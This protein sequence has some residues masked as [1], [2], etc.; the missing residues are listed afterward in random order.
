M[1][2]EAEDHVIVFVIDKKMIRKV[3][4]KEKV[5]VFCTVAGRPHVIEY[6]DLPESLA[7]QTNPDGSLR[8]NAGSIAIHI[9]E[10][11]FAAAKRDH[12]HVVQH[13][14]AQ[15]VELG[16]EHRALRVVHVRQHQRDR[17]AP[18]G[19]AAQV[20]LR[21][22]QRL[23]GHVHA[24]QH[25]AHLGAMQRVRVQAVAWRA[26]PSALTSAYKFRPRHSPSESRA[27]RHSGSRSRRRCSNWRTCSAEQALGLR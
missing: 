5:G 1:V 21:H 3:D 27:I 19:Q 18:P 7:K 22:R 9:I 24:R 6:S 25:L 26:S 17:L 2:I 12:V 11:A 4:P 13:A 14:L 15:L 10:L 23:P 16:L 20:R 8:F